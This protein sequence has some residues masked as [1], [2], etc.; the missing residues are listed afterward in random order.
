MTETG[1]EFG[2]VVRII[3]QDNDRALRARQ[4]AT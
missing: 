3:D 1:R 4:V 2:G